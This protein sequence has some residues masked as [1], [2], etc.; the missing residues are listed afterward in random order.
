MPFRI[1]PV[2]LNLLILNGLVFLAWQ[3]LGESSNTFMLEYF[4]LWKSD[5]I[6]P[7]DGSSEFF[8]PVQI[9]TSFFSHIDFLHVAFNM[10]ALV[11]F[12]T[13][14]ETTIG[15]KRFLTEYLVYG[16][17]AG[18]LIAF[19]DPSGSPVLG[20]ST[21]ISGLLVSYAMRFPD[22][23][24]MFFPIPVPL[25]A[26]YYVGILAGISAIFV[27]LSIVSGENSGRISHFGHFAG[28]LVAFIYLQGWKK[29]YWQR[30]RWR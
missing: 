5:L 29:S 9:V 11:S 27:T 10:L 18:I 30:N 3:L 21:A 22:A 23:Q 28:M 26:I 16:V 7:R 15:P 12:G 4:L 1:T 2:V 24:L 19:L 14:L 13:A 25:K 17:G 8:Q 20:A 6:L